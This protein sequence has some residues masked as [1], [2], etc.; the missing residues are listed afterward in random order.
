M[1]TGREAKT[2]I[3]KVVVTE[4]EAVVETKAVME[5]ES[6]TVSKTVTE[7]VTEAEIARH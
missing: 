2:K 1:E 5:T 3:V 6:E 7:T 4:P